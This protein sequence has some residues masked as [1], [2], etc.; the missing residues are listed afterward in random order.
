MSLITLLDLSDQYV[1][2][3]GKLHYNLYTTLA[4]GQTITWNIYAL[5][6]RTKSYD[7]WTD[8]TDVN[9]N[10][11]GKT[12]KVD[13]S[14]L[15]ALGQTYELVTTVSGTEYAK[16][17]ILS[18][19]ANII[20]QLFSYIYEFQT[21]DRHNDIAVPDSTGKKFRFS[22]RN[23]IRSNP[24]PIFYLQSTGWEVSIPEVD[25]DNGIAYYTSQ[26]DSD[27]RVL[28][29]IE[30]NYQ[31]SIFTEKQLGDFIKQAVGEVNGQKPVT[32]Y[33]IEGAP[34]EWD[35]AIVLGAYK[36]CYKRLQATLSLRNYA[37]LFTE[38]TRSMVSSMVS[39]L[40]QD[41]EGV[42]KQVKRRGEVS[43]QGV[44]S[45]SYLVPVSI[46]GT[47]WRDFLRV[48]F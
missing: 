20:D 14:K 27:N 9:G 3:D 40:S 8:T 22:D 25:Y 30:A 10:V 45:G 7:T 26:F 12:R 11:I 47:N 17:F 37:I 41:F 21:I 31:F 42:K 4:S 35:P 32:A 34:R 43:P 28:E 15:T 19:T 6:D 46:D 44:V 23:I 1:Y 13:K 39:Q 29:E 24:A 18:Y 38:D 2:W 16:S 5:D 48:S 33:N 36:Y